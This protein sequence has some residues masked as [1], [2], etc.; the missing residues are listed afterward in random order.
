MLVLW[1]ATGGFASGAS[2]RV[3]FGGARDAAAAD[4]GL[5]L[6]LRVVLAQRVAHELGVHEDAPQIGVAAEADAV[7]VVGL[8]LEPVH[9][10]P[11]RRDA[12]EAAVLLGHAGVQAHA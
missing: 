3:S 7:Q 1:L 12:V 2:G 5:P 11:D 4:Q 6:L 10:R 8:A 9:A